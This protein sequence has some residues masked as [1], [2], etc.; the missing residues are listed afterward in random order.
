MHME[1]HRCVVLQLYDAG[2][3][4]MSKYVMCTISVYLCTF[5]MCACGNV[6]AECVTKCSVCFAI[7]RENV[8]FHVR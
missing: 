1:I 7:C 5:C 6:F 2:Y 3:V 4:C 8:A